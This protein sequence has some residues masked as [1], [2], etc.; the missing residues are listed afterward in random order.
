M[1]GDVVS[2][3]VLQTNEFGSVHGE[4]ILPND[5][6]T[7]DY[8]I[9]MFCESYSYAYISVEEYKRP[10]FKSEFQPITETYKV[11]DSITVNGTAI[12]FA[13]SNITD[14]KVVYRVKR[15]V[16]YPNWYYW[17]RPYFN[18]EAQEITFGESKTND[19]GEF[20]ITFKAIP[21]ESVSKDNL[22]VFKYKVTADI[23]DINGETRTATTTVNVGY[24][25][26]TVKIVA[27]EL[28]NKTQKEV[29]LTLVSQNLN[30]EHT[31]AKGQLKIYKLNA[32]DRVLRTRPWQAPDYQTLSEDEFKKLFPHDPYN[33]EEQLTN[34]KKGEEVFSTNFDTEKDKT[35][36]LKKLK[37]WDS[38]KYIIVL[39]SE[40]KFGQTIKDEAYTTLFSDDDITIADTQLF[41][42]QLDKATYTQ[43]SIAKLT[44]GS[45]AKN[46]TVTVEIEKDSKIVMTQLVT[47]N[48]SKE[49]IIIPVLESD[50]GGFTVHTS[51]AAFNEF[52]SQSFLIN[53]PYPKTDLEIETTTFRDKLQPGQDETWSFK[54]KG[55]KGDKVSAELLASMYDAS[56]DEFRAHNWNFNPINNP[57]YYGRVNKNSRQSF[58]NTNFRLFNHFDTISNIHIK[59]MTN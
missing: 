58:G 11:N 50:L 46:I 12:A 38:G 22:P 26:M 37:K 32:P 10:K 51:F 45:A 27:P 14:A 21:D 16:K 6:L 49:T 3:H 40:D 55:P 52:K 24:H 1:N 31:P 42:A 43:G 28:I 17:R 4:F 56:L 19:K 29:E 7:G 57:A 59:V 54:I 30:G 36:I 41:E 48:N 13:G 44:I 34:W 33:N 23:T 8:T 18:S 5:G 39:E 15:E 2:G 47:L 20:D 53:V 9:D 35:I 25:A